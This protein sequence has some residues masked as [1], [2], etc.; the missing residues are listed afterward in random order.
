MATRAS[1]SKV[2]V[3]TDGLSNVGLG[4][5]SPES[6]PLEH[7]YSRVCTTCPCHMHASKACG[8]DTTSKSEISQLKMACASL[9]SAF[10]FGTFLLYHR[11]DSICSKGEECNLDQLGALADRTGGSVFRADPTQVQL[12]DELC[13]ADF[14]L[15]SAQLNRSVSLVAQRP[16]LASRVRCNLVLHSRCEILNSKSHH[17]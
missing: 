14:N 1:S 15:K 2:I 16:I 5:L 4:A 3:C 11:D 8:R 6:T 13:F 10:W 12:V 7:T 9:S 17:S